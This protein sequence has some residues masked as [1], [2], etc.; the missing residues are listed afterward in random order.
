MKFPLYSPIASRD[1]TLARDGF[2]KNAFVEKVGEA[3]HNYKRP[4]LLQYGTNTAA[5]GQ[6]ITGYFNA[7]GD[8][9]LFQAN[10]GTLYLAGLPTPP[11]DF[12][13]ISTT[14]AFALT[15]RELANANILRLSNGTLYLIGFNDSN[16]ASQRIATFTSTDN[17]ATWTKILDSALGSAGVPGTGYQYATMCVTSDDTIVMVSV[18]PITGN[19]FGCCTS[20]DGIT[21]T[22][23]NADV[24]GAS[25]DAIRCRAVV[26]HTDGSIYAFFT[27]TGLADVSDGPVFVSANKGTTWT[28]TGA[29]QNFET[30]AGRINYA[31][32]SH[33]SYLYVIGGELSSSG[34]EVWRSTDGTTWTEVGTDAF[35]P[36][37][38]GG[39]V[40]V[41]WV[42]SGAM[43]VLLCTGTN[44]DKV[45][46]SLTGAT[47]TLVST[48]T[49]SGTSD[50]EL[51]GAVTG[52][53]AN[54]GTTLTG[55]A[56][57]RIFDGYWYIWA[58]PA[59]GDTTVRMFR[60]T[61]STTTTSIG[62][63]GNGLLDF[64]Q[65]YAR[66][67]LI[68]KNSTVM[69]VLNTDTNVLT[70]VSDGDYPST[71]ARGVV[72][73]D[74][75]FFVMDTDGNIFNSAEEDATSWGASDFIAAQFEPDG[76]VAL[77]K[78]GLYIVAFGEYTSEY[79][80]N[81]GNATGSPLLPVQQGVMNVGCADG[82]TVGV[83]DSQLIWVA[84]SKGQGQSIAAG[85]FVAQAQ[86]NSYTKI[87][88]PAIDRILDADDFEDVDSTTFKVGGHSY[89]HLRLGSSNMSLVYDLAQ[90]Q[91]YVWTRRRDSFTQTLSGV[92]I[93]NGTATGTFTSSFADG[94]V[95][96]VSGFTGTYT[97][98]NGTFNFE[99]NSNV[100]KWPVTFT[101][102]ATSTGTGTA[103]G[104]SEDDLG[105][106]A[107]AGYQGKQI[108]QDKSSGDLFELDIDTYRDDSIYM[109]WS[110]RL[111]KLDLG[112]NENKFAS[113]ADLVANKVSGNVALRF[114]DDDCQ[115]FTRYRRRS[116][117]A[118][119]T[120]WHRLG[121]YRRRV[122][123]ARV[124]DNVPV[125]VEYLE[126]PEV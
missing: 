54:F 62:A 82:D 107:A 7:A 68:I 117:G 70:Q 105:I 118:E 3:F 2:M 91:W 35:T 57:F 83:I 108:L 115:N 119:R 58:S 96:V 97:A 123:E 44:L 14:D 120:R 66:T 9:F 50:P 32:L 76:G 111:P 13:P 79:F 88:T 81:A 64:T 99:V 102:T 74:G 60:G 45:Y 71:T 112:T 124:T 25:T 1:G 36:A 20:T 78:Y 43:Y 18:T 27:N 100:Y 125:M 10:G 33:G 59:S 116:L 19:N 80:W 24:R 114:S 94:D 113:W 37:D 56:S 26:A 121:D 77:A 84:Q 109:D 49:T 51:S 40:C 95:G 67:R 53:G 31:A 28:S 6:G 126:I 34:K 47:W 106:V 15:T 16:G 72:Y 52:S 5:T 75:F 48:I 29:T 73:L 90:Q 23:V 86:G 122:F 87:S 4:G 92:V 101:G 69:Y 103:T 11:A 89:Y 46:M 65:N 22:E 104:W 39:G 55:G 8:E 42:D 17:G 85:R 30:G 12:E 61:A 98:L 110:V 21:W 41:G 38:T 93:A 63:V